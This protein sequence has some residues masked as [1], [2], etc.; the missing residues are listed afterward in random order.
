MTWTASLGYSLSWQSL[1]EVLTF[2]HQQHSVHTNAQGRS[3]DAK[4][5]IDTTTSCFA[6]I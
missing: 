5:T 1:P 4:A 2:M 6:E 3:Q